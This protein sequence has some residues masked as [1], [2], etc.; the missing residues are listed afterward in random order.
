[1]LASFIIG[2]LPTAYW[3]GYFAQMQIWEWLKKYNIKPCKS[4]T[5]SVHGYM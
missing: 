3:F 5:I 1:M 4:W 2:S